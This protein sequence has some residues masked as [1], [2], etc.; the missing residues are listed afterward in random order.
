MSMW[1]IPVNNDCAKVCRD[2][3]CGLIWPDT[4]LCDYYTNRFVKEDSDGCMVECPMGYWEIKPTYII[5]G[6]IL[7]FNVISKYKV[8]KHMTTETGAANYV[9]GMMD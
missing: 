9:R 7:S 8:P 6:L 5:G 4:N 1:S 2:L 3:N